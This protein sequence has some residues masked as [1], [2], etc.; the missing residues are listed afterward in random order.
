MFKIYQ[1]NVSESNYK[2]GNVCCLLNGN[3]EFT[4]SVSMSVIR[5]RVCI[6]VPCLCPYLIYISVSRVAVLTSYTC[7]YLCLVSQSVSRVP[8]HMLV[9]CLCS[10][11]VLV[12]HIHFC[13]CIPCHMFVSC[14]CL[15]SMSVLHIHVCVCVTCLCPLSHSICLCHVRVPCLCLCFIYMSVSVS[16]V[17]YSFS[18]HVSV[19]NVRCHVSYIRVVSMSPPFPGLEGGQVF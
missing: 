17:T 19:S 18:C 8:C 2:T 1:L 3:L 11:S 15:V 14:S 12:L 9:S 6:R 16:H 4:A 7:L 13:V 5:D 10:M